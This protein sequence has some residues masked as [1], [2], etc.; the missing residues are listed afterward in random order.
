MST[1]CKNCG[2]DHIVDTYGVCSN[3]PTPD[4]VIDCGPGRQKEEIHQSRAV[5]LRVF[6]GAPLCRW[7]N[8]PKKNVLLSENPH[9]VTCKVCLNSK[10]Y[11]SYADGWDAAVE[12]LTRIV[13]RKYVDGKERG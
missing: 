10:A 4:G 11:K 7:R 5:H 8:P 6:G 9:D 13:L 3:V 12:E 1:T 2:C